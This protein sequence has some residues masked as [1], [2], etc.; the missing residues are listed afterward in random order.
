MGSSHRHDLSSSVNSADAESHR[1]TP[2]TKSTALSPEDLQ[3][4]HI[5]ST[6]VA[7]TS[8]QPPTF[9]LS[10]VPTFRGTGI[11][12]TVAGH[13]DPF[14][15]IKSGTVG[16]RPTG[17]PKLSP[18]APTFTPMGLNENDGG[19]IVSQAMAAPIDSNR[20]TY[21]YTPGS[22]PSASMMSEL[23][24]DHTSR[25]TYLTS[26][27]T[28]AN[29]FHSNPTSPGSLA[30]P[31]T[32]RQLPK[33][34]RFTSE[35]SISRCVMISQIDRSTPPSEIETVISPKTFQSRKGLVFD[36]LSLTGTVYVKFT[37][38][39]DAIDAVASLHRLRGDWLVQYLPLPS[40][41]L[42]S[43]EA[44]GTNSI[45]SKYEG[46]LFVKAYFSGPSPFFDLDTVSRLILDLLNNYGGLKA[47]YAVITVYPIV[48]YRAEFFDTKDAEHAIV[49]L[50]GF[51]IAGCTMSVNRYH[52]E[53]PL[54]IGE[55]DCNLGGHSHHMSLDGN[56]TAWL[57]PEQSSPIALRY[58]IPN[59]NFNGSLVPGFYNF[60]RQ[61]RVPHFMMQGAGNGSQLAPHLR[62]FPAL[63]LQTPPWGA[64]HSVHYGPGAV[65]QGRHSPFTSSNPVHQ[66]PGNFL[67]PRGRHVREQ[68][69]GYHNVVDVNRIRQG[70]DV[71]TTI[72]LRNIPN[73][74]NQF[75]IARSGSR[76]NCFNSDKVAE[77]S[78][79][80]IQGK[81]CLVQ[82]FRNSSVM[83]EHHSFRPK[84]FRTGDDAL[85]GTEEP[86]PGPDNESKMRRSVENAEHVGKALI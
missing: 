67:M 76:W 34:G 32:E 51:R 83:L 17:P 41:E 28:S 81:D 48:A 31:G 30:S 27:T 49:H 38:I 46:Q 60:E 64:F 21:L 43:R 84:I 29:A 79:A 56:S 77:V 23:A 22:L 2:D 7:P 12:S 39:R 68:S 18:I 35:G 47:Y 72:M 13:H 37:D 65:G 85:G 75:V 54:I 86:F 10:T 74:I 59:P 69:G 80:T 52:E 6:R 16:T 24:Y 50:N 82:K 53:G 9:S 36:H 78:Y 62:Q 15:T 66:V 14:V 11:D 55:E 57:T 61:G 3:P 44:F 45:A 63:N 26:P 8:N 5:T 33:L 73:K 20:S 71:R 58:P 19:S 25:E 1:G 42:H 70:A 40:R 4:K